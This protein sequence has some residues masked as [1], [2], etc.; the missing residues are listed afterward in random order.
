MYVGWKGGGRRADRERE[1]KTTTADDLPLLSLSPP[2]SQKVSTALFFKWN[3]Q[4]GPPYQVLVDTNFINFSIKNKV[5]KKKGGGKKRR[6]GKVPAPTPFCHPLLHFSMFSLSSFP[7]TGRPGP[8][9]DGLPVRPVHALHHRLRPGRTGKAG[10]KIPGR[11]EGRQGPPPRTPAL[12]ARG[13]VRGRL[14]GRPGER[15]QVLHRRHLRQGPAAPHS[16][17][18]GRAHHVPGGAAVHD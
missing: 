9:H 13:H 17:G 14:P 11:P 8:G 10:P 18:A 4:L 1:K 3:S 7:L 16:Q 12:R 5:Q 6:G 15:P 2:H